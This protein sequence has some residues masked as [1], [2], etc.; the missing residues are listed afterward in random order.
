MARTPPPE[1]KP[2][3]LVEIRR[4]LTLVDN[5]TSKV[6]RPSIYRMFPEIARAT[7]WRWID[8]EAVSSPSARELTQVAQAIEERINSGAAE[9]L[10]TMPSPGIVARD[11]GRALRKIDFGEEIK[12]LYADAEMLRAFAIK[13]VDGE[14]KIRN[15]VAFEKSIKARAGL[16]ETSLKVLQE[17]WDMRAMQQFYELIL[18]EIGAA[19]PATQ[20]RIVGRLAEL[21]QRYG[22]TMAMKL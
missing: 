10:P 16:I 3:C 11:G 5:D 7:I 2:E 13:H 9:H 8:I 15:P 6:D 1:R 14:E 22:M 18:E 20:K 17:I 4:Q 21:N 19:D 12:V